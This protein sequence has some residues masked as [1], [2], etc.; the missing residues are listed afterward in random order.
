MEHIAKYQL[1]QVRNQV[2]QLIQEANHCV[3]WSDK[4]LKEDI[5]SATNEKIKDYRRKLKKIEFALLENPSSALYGESQVG[6]SYLIKNLLSK[7]DE[8]FNIVDVSSGEKYD[9]LEKINPKGEGTEATSVVTR[10][11]T[12]VEIIDKNYPIKIRLLSPKDIVLMLADSYFSDV[13]DHSN[14][15]NG[16]KINQHID[17]LMQ[18]FNNSSLHQSF[19]TEDDV[20]DIRDY[21]A[22]NFKSF[23]TDLIPSKLWEFTAAIIER[24]DYSNWYKIFEIIWGKNVHITAIFNDLIE[25]LSQLGF[26]NIAY[27]EFKAVLR[28]YGTILHVARLREITGAPLYEDVV[29]GKYVNTVDL[30]IPQPQGNIHHVANK[31]KLCALTA[32]LVFK[33]ESE[34]ETQ[35]AFLKNSDLL[36]FPGAR[37]RLKNQE[38]KIEKSHIGDMVLRGKV[39]YIFNKYSA[40]Y[41][42]SNLFL[43]NRNQKIEVKYIPKLLNTWIETY[44]GDTPQKREE[45]LSN[46]QLPP[47]YVIYTFF[48]ADLEFNPINDKIDTLGEKWTKRFNTIFENEIVTNNFNW[49][50]NWTT[51]EPY[52]RNNYML[53]DF[54]YSN[55]IY[56]GY[57]D[58]AKKEEETP[59][60]IPSF[61]NYFDKLKESFVKHDFVRN[62]FDN[63]EVA[64]NESALANQDGS[65]LIIR[66]LSKTASNYAR[67][68]K[69]IRELNEIS[70][71]IKEEVEKHYHSDEADKRIRKA[72][73]QAGTIHINMDVVFGQDAYAF[74][75]FMKAFIIKESIVYNLYKEI[76]TK[77]ELVEIKNI[78]HYVLIRNSNP[79][80]RITKSYD[81]NVEILM[82]TYPQFRTKED[83]E[84]AFSAQ[85]IDLRELFY[86]EA[87]KLKNNSLALAETLRDHWFEHYLVKE[88]FESI[89]QLGF[90]ATALDD[91]FANIK[92]A[93]E[94]LNLVKI[95]AQNLRDYVDRFDKIDVAEEMIADISSGI[96]NKFITNFGWSFYSASELENLKSTN[97]ANHLGLNFDVD[98]G[99]MPIDNEE[100]AELFDHI[101][102]YNELISQVN[103]NHEVV[104]NFPNI[105]NISR[106]RDLM[107]ISFIANCNI[108]VYDILANNNLGEILSTLGKYH[109]QLEQNADTSN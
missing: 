6:K 71:G 99:S 14:L 83:L 57:R 80:L 67:T 93:F 103:L 12:Q 106:W 30:I 53:R 27:A 40:Q 66:N 25:Q 28:E 58:A 95:I 64:W 33:V 96:I 101:N 39:S 81:E 107:K 62:H 89:I 94:K 85:N 36:D 20:Y 5:R 92:T 4:F 13:E 17:Y 47:L 9:F 37:S 78:N 79:D 68:K 82:K 88:R 98:N 21:L 104:K 76:L 75:N 70:A 2:S 108:P 29:S 77:I 105:K 32:E 24:V 11:S 7:A 52:F 23:T 51:N 54:H 22:Q 63:P 8:V 91:L 72:A 26:A 55:T 45:F 90:S 73:E 41:L 16:D 61:P 42:I 35:K 86:G 3:Q 69:F 87:M 56:K 109:F 44:I 46:S 74:G 65:A 60:P 59:I 31:S 48:N 100:L 49:H 97:Q 84:D 102:E 50:K 43:C 15:P 1:T 19:F 34:I 38:S 10:F 18:T